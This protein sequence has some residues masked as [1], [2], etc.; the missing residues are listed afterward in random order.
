MNKKTEE[1]ADVDDKNAN[2]IFYPSSSST[3]TISNLNEINKTND[4]IYLQN[5]TTDMLIKNDYFKDFLNTD[6]FVIPHVYESIP[7][8]HYCQQIPPPYASSM[9]STSSN[10]SY[11]IDYSNTCLLLPKQ[12]ISPSSGPILV[13]NGQNYYLNPATIDNSQIQLSTCSSTS[14]TRPLTN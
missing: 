4:F 12:T 13:L 1:A 9:T 7:S 10:N 5:A 6:N 2:N 3:P 8:V 14:S 11:L